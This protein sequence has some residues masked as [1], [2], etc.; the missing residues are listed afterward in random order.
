MPLTKLTISPEN[1][2]YSFID[3]S[4]VNSVSLEGGSSRYRRDIVGATSTVTVSWIFNAIEYDYFRAFYRGVSA[5]GS[6]PFLIDLILDDS[7]LIE[8]EVHFIVNSVNLVSQ[9]GNSYSVTAQL[10][11]KPKTYDED[12]DV[13]FV[14]LYN[15]YGEDMNDVIQQLEILTNKELPAHL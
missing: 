13:V 12:D 2:A 10:E 9:Q 6:K 4:E 15:S 1:T 11:V 8:H 7:E 14:D 3:G 5:K